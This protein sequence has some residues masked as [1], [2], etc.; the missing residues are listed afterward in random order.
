M[1]TPLPVDPAVRIGQLE[2]GLTFFVREN[3]RPASRAEL[4]LVVDAGSILETPEQRGLAHL[5][6]HMAFNGTANFE[7]QELVDYLESV[8]MAFGPSVN[9]YTSFD[10]TVY[11][12][13]IP[14]DSA[15]IVATAFQILEDWAHRITLDPAEVDQERGVVIEEW[16][17]GRGAAARMSDQQLPVMFEGSRYAE[18]LP[19]GDPEVLESFPQEAIERFYRDWYRPD[20]MA[21]V[22]VGDFDADEVVDRIRN[23]FGRI[24]ARSGPERT[25][26]TVPDREG[27]RYA[28]ASD[29]EASASRIALL[30]LQDPQPVATVG[31]Y[32]RS[33]VEGLS[34]RMLNDRL[35][36]RAQQ[37]D[38][39]F[40][41]AAAARGRFVRPKSAYQLVAVVPED[42]H[43]RGMEAVLTEAERAA[44]HGFTET[45]L[46][47]AKLDL[48][49]GLER[50]YTDRE[51]QPSA[52]FAAEYVQRF[53]TDGPIPGIDFAFGAGQALVPGIQIDEV[54]AVARENLAVEQR[55]ILVDAV[56]SPDVT[57]P[58]PDELGP[59]FDRVAA[60]DIEPWVDSSVDQPLVAEAPQPGSVVTEERMSGLGVTTW[61]LSNGI[62]IWL[63]PTDFK[64][65]EVVLRATSPG[66][67]SRSAE[68]DH[69]SAT[70][71]TALVQ[72]GGVGAFSRIDL[73]KALAGK[74]VAVGPSIGQR[75]EG[76]SGGGSP[77]D[78]ETLLQL[79]YLYATAPREDTVAF[80]AFRSQMSALL[81][82]RG[83]SPVAAFSD[84][85]SLTL[86]QYHPRAEPVT[87]AS[88]DEIDLGRAVDFYRDRFASAEDFDF[89]LVGAFDVDAVRPLVEQWLGGLPAAARDDDWVDLGITPPP[90]VVEKVV[91]AG[92]EPQSRTV[93][94]FHG[95]MDYRPDERATLRV[96]AAVVET[97]LREELRESLGGTYS[98]SVSPGYERLPDGRYTLQVGFGSDPE[99]AEELRAAVF[100]EIERLK[101]EGP[102][103]ED[104]A[105]ALEGALRSLETSRESNAWW[106]TQLLGAMETGEDPTLTTAPERYDGIDAAR[107]QEA[108]R[109]Y[110]DGDQYV[111]VV[112]L[113]RAGA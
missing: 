64:E 76:F 61:E 49:R 29:P 55:V 41:F 99:R 14:T 68:D 15:E 97:R 16:R 37:A 79:V 110:L 67:W 81:A 94:I 6:E 46:E 87:A 30:S 44:R 96:L 31:D 5:L 20:L 108:A 38:P 73:Q 112:L 32:R 34:N 102:S 33:L 39:P 36:E 56:E 25:A 88:L 60:S 69:L 92:V 78:L 86:A 84:T 11:M 40:A 2:N 4:R 82:N 70:V 8:G 50:D 3:S 105:S 35:A 22:A 101:A 90:G 45:E 48:L 24:E 42:G 17:L 27:T 74:A 52:R 43:A 28:I 103:D 89:V 1:D 111:S 109:R 7:K 71:A 53:L 75:T 93:V 57:V 18:R 83:A 12:L 23:H 58:V 13:Q 10:E 59:I 62:R 21:V 51:N 65:D 63:K 85:L 107:V 104:V 77:D 47:R 72:Q 54:D 66:G 9:A 91:R 100:A 95:P 106:A 98:V 26:F 113:P 19:I 80:E